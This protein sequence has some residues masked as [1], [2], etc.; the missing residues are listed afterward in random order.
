MV[1][2]FNVIAIFKLSQKVNVYVTAKIFWHKQLLWLNFC[3]KIGSR[4]E[5]KKIKSKALYTLDI[6]TRDIAINQGKLLMKHKVP[7][8]VVR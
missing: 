7:W 4:S 8:F 1:H 5:Q 3:Y 6:F 2:Y